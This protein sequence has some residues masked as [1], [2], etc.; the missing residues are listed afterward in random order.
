MVSRLLKTV[1]I[2]GLMFI[3]LA[4]AISALDLGGD[5]LDQF[6]DFESFPIQLRTGTR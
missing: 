3:A 2:V 5:P 4:A 1:V 6:E